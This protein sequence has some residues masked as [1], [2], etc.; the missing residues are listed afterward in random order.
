MAGLSHDREHSV[1]FLYYL[2]LQHQST[3]H[4]MCRSKKYIWYLC[5]CHYFDSEE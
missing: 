1:S 2:M 4:K 3:V 5:Q